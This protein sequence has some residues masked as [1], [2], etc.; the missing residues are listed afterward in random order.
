VQGIV[1]APILYA[2]EE[3]PQL[4]VVVDRGFDDPADVDLVSIISLL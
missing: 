4:G 3:F 1:T 2:I